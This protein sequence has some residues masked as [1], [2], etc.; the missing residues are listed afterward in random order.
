MR[1]KS[2]SPRPPNHVKL[3]LRALSP[4][5]LRSQLD[6]KGGDAE[7]GGDDDDAQHDAEGD[8]SSFVVVLRRG[9]GLPSGG[10]A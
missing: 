9:L 8:L 10:I 3:R 1:S 5:L 2:S 4:A 6:P 7:D